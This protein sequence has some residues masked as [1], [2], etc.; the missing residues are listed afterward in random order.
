MADVED[1]ESADGFLRFT[2]IW[3][4]TDGVVFT[5]IDGIHEKRRLEIGS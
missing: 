5:L 3:S 2:E 1:K 4:K